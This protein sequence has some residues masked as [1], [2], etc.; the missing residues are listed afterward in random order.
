M[1][2]DFVWTGMNAHIRRLR[3]E[4]GEADGTTLTWED[5]Q[6][7]EQQQKQ[8]QQQQQPSAAALES[9]TSQE[10]ESVAA[11]P[12]ERSKLLAKAIDTNPERSIS[13]SDNSATRVVN[14]S[15]SS[16]A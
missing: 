12:N 8:Q 1:E 4:L 14:V 10:L 6:Q 15:V 11:D 13:A 2:H 16:I 3:D 7:R 5:K 9:E